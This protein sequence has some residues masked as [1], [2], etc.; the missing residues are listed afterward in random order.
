MEKIDIIYDSKISIDFKPFSSVKLEGCKL[1]SLAN[2][3][4]KQTRVIELSNATLLETLEGISQNV[5]E[6]KL[7]YCPKLTDISALSN[8]TMLRKFTLMDCDYIE[9]LYGLLKKLK[10]LE[11][12]TLF[13]QENKNLKSVDFIIDT[14]MQYFETNYSIA[15]NDLKPLLQLKDCSILKW[16]KN[17]NLRDIDLPHL[18]VLYQSNGSFVMKKL[19]EINNDLSDPNIIWLDNANKN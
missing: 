7:D 2:L 10:M 19:S 15:D 9:G 6:V 16:K 12:L 11:H 4:D 18:S 14:P 3:F 8:C 13:C 1:K 17:Y 5:E